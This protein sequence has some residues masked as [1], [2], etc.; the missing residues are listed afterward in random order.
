MDQNVG[1]QRARKAGLMLT[2]E[3]T[4]QDLRKTKDLT[5][6]E[7]YTE[8]IVNGHTQTE[9]AKLLNSTVDCVAAALR[10][11]NIK[12][13]PEQAHDVMSRGAK[14]V[15]LTPEQKKQKELKNGFFRAI[16]GASSV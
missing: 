5:F 3:E 8:Y 11:F 1:A 6:E 7:L 12:R 4:K 9:T 16:I 15:R 13:T 2:Y 10:K 14:K